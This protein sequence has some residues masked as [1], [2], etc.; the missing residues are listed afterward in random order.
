MKMTKSSV[1]KYISEYDGRSFLDVKTMLAEL[2]IEK[3]DTELMK[4]SI[5]IG[6]VQRDVNYLNEDDDGI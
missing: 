2:A 6:I 1:R 3:E 4:L 5:L